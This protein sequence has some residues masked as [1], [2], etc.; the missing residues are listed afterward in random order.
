MGV[1]DGGWAMGRRILRQPE[2]GFAARTASGGVWAY[3][4]GSESMGRRRVGRAGLCVVAVSWMLGCGWTAGRAQTRGQAYVHLD[5]PAAGDFPLFVKGRAAAVFVAPEEPAAVHMAADAFAD[6]VERVTGVRPK[7]LSTLDHAPAELVVVGVVGGWGQRPGPLRGLAGRLETGR[8]LG[9]WES[10]VTQVVERPFPGVRRALVIA[11]SDRRGAAYA[12]FTLSREMGV[13]PWT[14]WADVPVRHRDAVS[15]ARGAEVQ[16]EP[17]VRY[18]GIF[19]NDEDWGLRPWAARKMD[20]KVGNLGPNTYARVFELLLRLRANTLWPAMH[21]GTLAF[22]ALPENARLADTWG[23][24]MGSSHSEALL[25]NNVGE[26]DEKRDGPWNYQTNRAAIDRYWDERL[27]ENGRFENFYTV[28][29]RGVHDTGLEATGTAEVKAR[30]VEQVMAAQRALLAKR[31]SPQVETIPQV[32]WLYKES[33]E[34]Y[35]AGMKVPDDVTLGWTDDNYGYVRQLPTAAEQRR[36]GGS[37][38]YYHVSYWG[39]PHDYLWLCTTPPALIREEMTK[40]YDHGAR[41]FWVLNVGDLKPAEA[42]LDYFMQLAWDEPAMASVDQQQFLRTWSAEQFPAGRA[43]AIAQMMSDYYRLSFIRKPEFM[44]FNGYDDGINRTS[45]N[46]L[47]WGDQNATRLKEWQG[48]SEQAQALG[49]TLPAAY[50]DAYFELVGYPIEAAAAQNAKFLLTDRSFL[51]EAEGHDAEAQVAAAGA[52]AAYARIGALTGEYNGLAGGK[53]DGMMSDAPRDRQ[54]FRMP[55]TATLADASAPLPRDWKS[56]DAPHG[57]RGFDEQNKTISMNAAEFSRKQDVGG[58]A[59]WRVLPQLGLSGAA[60]V[61]GRPG[62]VASATGH[63][64]PWLEYSFTSRSTEPATLTLHLLPTFPV[65]A[66][67]RQRF[68][69]AVDDGASKELDLSGAGE[70]KENSAPTWAANVL[71]NSAVLT[72][73]LGVLK[74]GPHRLRLSYE[75][76]GV[77]FE[78]LVVSFPGAVPAYPFAPETGTR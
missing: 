13:S 56:G 23:I 30:L 32:I 18:R 43:D 45:F 53:W 10:A 22:N 15:V 68:R 2:D 70:W 59:A 39:F 9:R 58:G 65:D 25:R 26:W 4:A 61:Y 54:V 27:K 37:G 14:W 31:V 66:E 7:V 57:G 24:V 50:N 16:G 29:M 8:V 6:D 20:P 34:L 12:L 40:A 48:L 71:R 19:L 64:A 76:P 74:P 52:R 47:G 11:G 60:V 73:P 41:R 63:D 36:S 62:L 42:D 55:R 69:V 78:Q 33:L 51:D 21:P 1:G 46:P 77:V 5:Q 44:G 49:K 72:L 17:S 38:V 3:E 35:R 28:G 67:H 75:D